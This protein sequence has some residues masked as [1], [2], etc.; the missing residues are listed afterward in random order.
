MSD[1]TAQQ[2]TILQY[3]NEE[4]VLHA[5]TADKLVAERWRRAKFPVTILGTVGGVARTWAVDLGWDA[6]RAR[7]ERLWA[8]T[9]PPH[10][11]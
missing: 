9:I 5:C 7:W 4:R 1:I 2:E 10:W 11:D 3:D 6:G 8:E